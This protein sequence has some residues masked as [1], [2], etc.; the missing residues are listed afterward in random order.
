MNFLASVFRA[1]SRDFAG[2]D[3]ACQCVDRSMLRIGAVTNQK[4]VHAGG[5]AAHRGLFDREMCA[6]RFHFKVVGNDRAFELA[7]VAQ[8]VDRAAAH[9]CRHS[10][11]ERV[12][13]DMRRHDRCDIRAGGGAEGRQLNRAQAIKPVWQYRQLQMAVLRRIAVP[14]K[15]LPAGAHALRLH[16]VDECAAHLRDNARIGAEA[17]VADHWVV[18]IGVNVQHRRVIQIDIDGAQLGADDPANVTRERFIAGQSDR[19]H[20]AD[21]GESR[22]HPRDAAA[23]LVDRREKRTLRRKLDVAAKFGHLRRRYDVA[24]EEN[25][26]ADAARNQAGQRVRRRRAVEPD[27]P[28]PCRDAPCIHGATVSAQLRY[29]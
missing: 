5:D 7:F 14:G 15:M 20:R 28:H 27:A 23:F 21:M 2:L 26:A 6:D 8:E 9:G 25:C 17:P 19:A 10:G 11:V 16:A 3:R 22:A 12:E 1:L 29:F 13:H 18:G 4:Q 24:R